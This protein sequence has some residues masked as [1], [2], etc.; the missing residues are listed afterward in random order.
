MPGAA[1]LAGVENPL[2]A[3]L[4]REAHAAP[5]A[6]DLVEQFARAMLSGGIPV[7]R[8]FLT[9]RTLHPLLVATG[10]VWEDNGQGVRQQPY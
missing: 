6:R 1:T 2:V 3:W 9:I 7:W 4:V 8:I 10:Y 5:S